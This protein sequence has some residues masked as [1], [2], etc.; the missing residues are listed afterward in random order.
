[1]SGRFK[2]I[3][4]QLYLLFYHNLPQFSKTL[5]VAQLHQHLV[6]TLCIVV[7]L[8]VFCCN[9]HHEVKDYEGP[10]M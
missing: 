1:M 8:G 6:F 9:N 2:I 10:E 4:I 7:D 5:R 3:V